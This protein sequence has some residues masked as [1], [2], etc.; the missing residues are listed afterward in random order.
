MTGNAFI[1][2]GEELGMKGAGRDENRR[3]PM[4]WN[5]DL[6]GGRDGKRPGW[7]G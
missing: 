4:Y 1:Y 3:A 7:H 5:D 2:Y 6:A